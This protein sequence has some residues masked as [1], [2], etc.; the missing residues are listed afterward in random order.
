MIQNLLF[1]VYLLIADFLIGSL[2]ANK[3]QQKRLLILQ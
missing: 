3:N 1:G 2:K